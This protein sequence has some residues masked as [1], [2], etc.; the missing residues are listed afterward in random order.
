MTSLI[1]NFGHIIETKLV[2]RPQF[3]GL[4][5]GFPFHVAICA[6]DLPKGCLPPKG[7]ERRIATGYAANAEEA[8]VKAVAEGV[9]RYSIQYRDSLP[10]QLLPV[11]DTTGSVQPVSTVQLCLG[12]PARTAFTSS[13]GSAAAA[14]FSEA[15]RGAAFELI[16]HWFREKIFDRQQ[17]AFSLSPEINLG[18]QLAEWL[19]PQMRQVSF[20]AAILPSVGYVVLCRNSDL[21]FGRPTYGSAAGRNIIQVARHASFE[22]LFHWYNF[23]RMEA[24]CVVLENFDEEEYYWGKVFRGAMRAPSWPD[25][26]PLLK[27]QNTFPKRSYQFM[28]ESFANHSGGSFGLFDFSIAELQLSVARIVNLPSP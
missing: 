28:L 13:R 26:G 2:S 27:D 11:F 17:P 12:A 8:A 6:V 15:A 16:E 20:L 22:A 23:A 9:E 18:S 4:P 5:T 1:N 25:E 24:N 10:N 14:K 21:D 7:S 19:R 3:P